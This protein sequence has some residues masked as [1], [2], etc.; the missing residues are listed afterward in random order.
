MTCRARRAHLP[1]PMLWRIGFRPTK[2]AEIGG[3]YPQI[4]VAIFRALGRDASLKLRKSNERVAEHMAAAEDDPE[5]DRMVAD[6]AEAQRAFE[7]WDEP[8]VDALLLALAQAVAAN[9]EALAASRSRKPGSATSPTRPSRIVL[10]VETSTNRSPESRRWARSGVRR[11]ASCHRDR[12]PRRRRLRDR[13]GHQSCRVRDFQD[14]DRDQ[15]AQCADPQLSSHRVRRRAMRSARSS[16]SARAAPAP[17]GTVQVVP[18]STADARSREVHEPPEG[19]S[20]VS[21]DRRRRHREGGLPLGHAGDRRRSGQC[22]AFVAV[23]A[24]LEAAAL[25]IVSSKP[26]R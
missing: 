11:R 20:L 8:R 9:A 12:E 14:A 22:P 1:I 7:N 4:S 10:R 6:A 18:S 13:A 5:I 24:D 26:L 19:V 21:G 16:R 15:D 3:D 2:L 23:D 17:G 25:A